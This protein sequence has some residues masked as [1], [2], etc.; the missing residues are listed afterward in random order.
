MLKIKLRERERER[1]GHTA[2]PTLLFR[3]LLPL[4]SC[5]LVQLVKADKD[6][7]PDAFSLTTSP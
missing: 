3:F 7:K 5:H 4:K 6:L 1:V 2:D